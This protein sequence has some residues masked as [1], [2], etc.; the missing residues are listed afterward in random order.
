MVVIG[1]TAVTAR[2]TGPKTPA[3][4]KDTGEARFVKLHADDDQQS[5]EI[6]SLAVP[7]GSGGVTVGPELIRDATRVNE[8]P[9]GVLAEPT[10]PRAAT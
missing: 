3:K 10:A 8:A 1:A 4:S 9:A 2:D 5:G 6:L 7:A